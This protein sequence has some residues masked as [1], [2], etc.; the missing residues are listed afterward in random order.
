MQLTDVKGE[1]GGEGEPI[2][3]SDIGFCRY[4]TALP[5]T[6]SATMAC[7]NVEVSDI[8]D[9]LRLRLSEAI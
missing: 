4:C 5:W 8:T 6:R 7:E 3:S 2:H 1:D 9:V